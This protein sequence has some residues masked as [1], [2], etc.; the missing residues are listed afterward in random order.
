MTKEMIEA[1]ADGFAALEEVDSGYSHAKGIADATRGLSDSGAL[2]ARLPNGNANEFS[3][4]ARPLYTMLNQRIAALE[5]RKTLVNGD[6]R[7]RGD[8]R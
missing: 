6:F 5:C 4:S 2:N 7:I 1:E 8:F 3:E